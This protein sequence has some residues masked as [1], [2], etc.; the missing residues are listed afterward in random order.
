MLDKNVESS[1]MRRW[2]I[3]VEV[4][5]KMNNLPKVDDVG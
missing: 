5:G 2:E 4:S 1:E 3:F